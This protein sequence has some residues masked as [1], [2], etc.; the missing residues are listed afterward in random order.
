MIASGLLGPSLSPLLV[1][2][3]S[4]RVSAAYEVNGLRWGMMMVPAA[5]VLSSIAIFIA[6]KKIREHLS[7]A[8]GQ[9]AFGPAHL[10]ILSEK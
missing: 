3:I 1:G 2:M 9:N 4:D 7:E 5:S 8:S 6:S 10:V